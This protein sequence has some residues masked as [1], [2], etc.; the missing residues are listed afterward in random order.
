MSI[1]SSA[2]EERKV[3]ADGRISDLFNH[4]AFDDE[5][6]L[7]LLHDQAVGFCYVC[8]P[9]SGLST[10][11]E[12]RMRTMLDLKWPPGTLLHFNLYGSPD[13]APIIYQHELVRTK[14]QIDIL[15]TLMDE[16]R[17]WIKECSITP[18]W[19]T[20]YLVRNAILLVSATM[21]I[22][23]KFPTE[24][25]MDEAVKNKN[26]VKETLTALH[27]FPF[28][29]DANLYVKIFNTILTP[30]PTAS[31]RRPGMCRA[32][33]TIPLRNQ[34]SDYDTPLT[35][36]R[37]KFGTR[38][39]SG[40][41][42]ITTLS[43]KEYPL[44]EISFGFSRSLLGDPVNSL[45]GLQGTV[46]ITTVVHIP[47]QQKKS[48]K[49]TTRR[50]WI[51][52]Q[53]KG[54][55]PQIAPILVD[56][57]HAF[58]NLT[59]NLQNGEKAMEVYTSVTLFSNS[60]LE[61]T[62]EITNAQGYY[63]E[64]GINLLP[65]EVAQ[66]PMFLATLPMNAE[67]K[68]IPEMERFR[69]MSSG[70]TVC[71]L[72]VFGEWKGN[73]NPVLT[74]IG[75]GGQLTGFDI[76]SSSTN[77]NC[78]IAAESGAGKSFLTNDIICNALAKDGIVWAID[79]GGSY[80]ELCDLLE[81]D[82]ISFGE[83]S[84]ICLNP[85][86][87][88]T[89]FEEQVDGLVEL[90]KAMA[91]QTGKLQ[92][93]QTAGLKKCLT[94]LWNH[95]G[96]DLT[97]DIVA[98]ELKDMGDK[99][100]MDVG[101]QIYSFT[102]KGNFGKYFN[103]PN[104]VDFKNSFTV[105]ELGELKGRPHLQTVVLLQLMLQILS[106]CYRDDMRG[107]EKFLLI[108]EAWDLLAKGDIAAFIEDAYRRIRKYG[109]SCTVITQ[110][111]GDLHGTPTGKVIVENSAHMFL[112]KQKPDAID[113]LVETKQLNLDEFEQRVMKSVTTVKGKYSEIYI[114]SNMGRGVVRLVVPRMTSLLYSTSADEVA[115][116]KARREN[117]M[118]QMEAIEDLM[119]ERE[120]AGV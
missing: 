111:V 13:I 61:R 113:A 116:L 41:T 54:A 37:E 16:R 27:A 76:F 77:Y 105:L 49:L 65:D 85:F 117:G 32:D 10:G 11:I 88:I 118:G 87:L 48:D 119:K 29:M 89:D 70:D 25:E 100:L 4:M 23:A 3:F 67:T 7:F 64:L 45:R 79:A 94:E 115:A 97:I 53:S 82:Y 95:H 42:L 78:F 30:T 14:S 1:A 5:T 24:E 22:Q 33:P 12:E 38:L 81:G 68:S 114:R 71:L 46:M 55:M 108:D 21:P 34:I 51:M 44:T 62:R 35:L 2:S 50:G 86:P 84:Q 104:T 63:S 107:L 18:P 47:H 99:R 90:I 75:R 72:P 69:T 36:K 26:T 92:D 96:H 106:R 91:T 93:F 39:K 20:E 28:P 74:F 17:E 83:G 103:G 52:N 6:G 58:D 60:E 66:L 15:N 57:K 73:G 101:D 40:K 19:Q 31:W 120:G 43:V 109:G 8:S 59:K 56:K 9:I 110:G 112:L 80:K 102:S 98:D